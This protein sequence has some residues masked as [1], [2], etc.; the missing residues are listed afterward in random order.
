MTDEHWSH[1]QSNF[2]DLNVE[3][4]Y[5]KAH[6]FKVQ[7][8]YERRFRV[9]TTIV[10]RNRFYDVKKQPTRDSKLSLIQRYVELD[11]RDYDRLKRRAEFEFLQFANDLDITNNVLIFVKNLLRERR[12]L[13][14]FYLEKQLTYYEKIGEVDIIH[15]FKNGWKELQ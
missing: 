4:E 11:I 5:A 2:D 3:L 12:G 13:L 14:K 1:F 7:L 8:D 6:T 9:W 15:H 10:E